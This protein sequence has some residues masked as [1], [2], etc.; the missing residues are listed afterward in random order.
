M[1]NEEYTISLGAHRKETAPRG[2]ASFP[3]AAYQ[4]DVQ[5]FVAGQIIPHWHHEI[6]WFFLLDG[7]VRVSF[8]DQEYDLQPRSGYLANSNVLHSVDC[9]TDQHCHYH[10]IVFDPSIISGAPGSVFEKSY[11]RPF[12]DLGPSMWLFDASDHGTT[13]IE[14]LFS[15]AYH[16]FE[17]E[18]RGYEFLVRDVLSRLI[19]QL[20]D[21]SALAT[22]QT[23]IQDLRV[24]QMLSWLDLH[25]REHITIEQLAETAGIS[26]R[27]C[28]RIFSTVLHD[29]PMK[30]L[31]R[32]RISS[33]AE[34]L[35]STSGSI[36][37]IA[38]SCGF[39]SASYFSKQF[40]TL[41]GMTPREYRAK[42]SA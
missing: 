11:V 18:P 19:V 41:T 39:D 30:Y 16:A 13:D 5:K 22:K 21:D 7:H 10:S 17:T 15:D 1:I 12:L 14:S 34:L 38:T 24:K 36:L 2:T 33:A 26:V 4:G 27:E 42:H 29:T 32:R 31:L 28:Q 6:E 9:M 25:Y 35:A 3:C 40:K 37:D 20:M 8:I 23:V